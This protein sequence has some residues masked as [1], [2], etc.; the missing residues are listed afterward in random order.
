MNKKIHKLVAQKPL[1]MGKQQ[2]WGASSTTAD[3]GRE[4]GISGSAGEGG[5]KERTG[6]PVNNNN[7]GINPSD[8]SAGM[9]NKLRIGGRARRG[10]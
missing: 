10:R 1:E 7:S 2:I 5:G 8:G 4:N 9:V 6:K 3:E